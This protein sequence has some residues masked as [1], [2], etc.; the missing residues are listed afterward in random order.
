MRLFAIC[1]PS[2]VNQCS[3]YKFIT[4]FTDKALSLNKTLEWDLTHG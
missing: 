4:A 2:L 3:F 1:I